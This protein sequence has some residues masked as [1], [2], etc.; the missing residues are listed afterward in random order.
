MKH[1]VSRF[2][3]RA[4]LWAGAFGWAI[5]ANAY[6]T[7]SPFWGPTGLGSIPTTDT[8]PANEFEAGLSYEKI[9]PTGADV[10]Q[11]PT[12][13]ATYGLK[14]GEIGVA[15][16]RERTE[17]PGLTFKND[18]RAAHA[19]W[20]L[21]GKPGGAQ[22]AVG[23]HYLDFGDVPGHVTTYYAT[24]S[25]PLLKG[26]RGPRFIGHLGVMHNRI[27]GGAPA[28]ETRPMAGLEWRAGHNCVIAGDYIWKKGQASSISSLIA[29]YQWP[30]GLTAQVGVGQFRGDDNRFL[31]G[32]S[33]RFNWK[34]LG[35]DDTLFG[36]SST[37]DAAKETKR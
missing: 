20:R 24:G 30:C 33:Y 17:F 37:R 12:A 9:S 35:P 34:G 11:F 5:G 28:N 7:Q 2:A 19:K 32:V 26:K 13:T 36:K 27:T 6:P 16:D 23:V 3:G 10:R 31:A 18:Y 4:M 1:K 29:R 22:A 25:L 14:N 8:V 15:Y 21:L